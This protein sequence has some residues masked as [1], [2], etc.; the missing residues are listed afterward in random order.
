MSLP[1]VQH[2]QSASSQQAERRS[3]A[4]HA[5]R[6]TATRRTSVSAALR[7]VCFPLL[8][9]S[10]L[11]ACAYQLHAT[12]PPGKVSA[13]HAAVSQ[14][15]AVAS[16][17][18]VDSSNQWE[19]DVTTAAKHETA[20][21][22]VSTTAD[23]DTEPSDRPSHD[24]AAVPVR[25]R[26]FI[27]NTPTTSPPDSETASP[28]GSSDTSSAATETVATETAT[29][30]DQA[31]SASP[32][33]A[34]TPVAPT[35]TVQASNTQILVSWLEHYG[36]WCL[37]LLVLIFL[38]LLFLIMTRNR[39]RKRNRPPSKRRHAAPLNDPILNQQDRDV[40]LSTEVHDS[41]PGKATSPVLTPLTAPAPDELSSSLNWTYA[42]SDYNRSD[43]W[44]ADDMPTDFTPW[45][46][47]RLIAP[48]IEPDANVSQIEHDW[49][50]LPHTQSDNTSA[51]T[52]NDEA[53]LST[54]QL[55]VPRDIE[56]SDD[57]QENLVTIETQSPTTTKTESFL[58]Q[59]LP[60]SLLE[61]QPSTSLP[62]SVIVEK[63]PTATETEN[64]L[65]QAPPPS[66]LETQP[67]TSLQA[68]VI[69]EDIALPTLI[70]RL[71]Q[72]AAS[73]NDAF[74]AFFIE[75]NA[76]LPTIACAGHI[77]LYTSMLLDLEAMLRQAMVQHEPNAAW[78]L[79]QVLLMRIA[80]AGRTE[81]DSLHAQASTLAQQGMADADELELSQW[82][83]RLIDIDLAQ[84][85]QQ[86]GATRLLALRNMQ[87][88]YASA[89]E[90]GEGAVLQA[91]VDVLLHWAQC[92]RGDSALGKYAEAEQVCQRLR[93][94]PNR[95]DDAQRLLAKV[96]VHRATVEQG[97]TRMKGLD[98]AQ[99][100]L[101]ELFA[102][103]PSAEV[104]L[105]VAATALAR[106]QA[107]LPEQA[108]QAYSHALMHAFLA[109]S[110]PRWRADS[111]QCRLD[112]QLSYES[113]PEM[114]TQGQ[115]ALDLAN[116]LVTLQ[117][118][119]PET[120][121]RMAQAYL[122][123]AEFARA[124]QLCEEAC[125][126]DAAGDAL[127]TTWQEASKQW[128]ASLP[129]PNHHAAWHESERKR[130]IAS[131]RH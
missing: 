84:A 121:N 36:L 90:R 51:H 2:E 102:R 100:L 56:A 20:Q 110:D 81:V 27:A 21:S 30:Q 119:P 65:A 103:T 10:L 94:I 106:G 101:D 37:L 31:T 114:S 95:A 41:L 43:Y 75:S 127:L 117:T 55:I 82:E 45:W 108:K 74:P 13:E 80:Q 14:S 92:Q 49:L 72:M 17:S 73:G 85:T 107:M 86:K 113:L 131:H 46:A 124:C 63:S 99:A 11:A 8:I 38:A 77:P 60:P 7:Y 64:V 122:R 47:L 5:L 76:R 118:T 116:R 129:Q 34:L 48:V 29:A 98:T 52:D 59:P 62:A 91:W 123:N 105:D 26:E 3:P 23:A 69:V 42:E 128:A 58:A 125:R 87:T 9:S 78:L 97:G 32:S 111:L 70:D 66:L 53:S 33:T 71:E 96:L 35:T 112:I 19:S 16:S 126:S 39:G 15:S 12:R 83:A 44:S 79:V 109:E 54:P 61:T 1:N 25:T 40:A 18:K 104:A 89:I 88:R 68:S 57:T 93:Q 24:A 6:G 67:S 50:D 115:V 22:E 4:T 130:R 28:S 120:L